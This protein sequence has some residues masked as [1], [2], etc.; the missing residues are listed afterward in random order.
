MIN[1]LVRTGLAVVTAVAAMLSLQVVFASSASAES[2]QWVGSGLNRH[3]YC[4]GVNHEVL[5]AKVS[6]GT[7]SYFN[8]TTQNVEASI[9]FNG[10]LKDKLA[11]GRCTWLRW[12]A[13][14]AY[15]PNGNITTSDK[16]KV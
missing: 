5:S 15:W 11:D 4:T 2:C 12:K 13:T 1:K 8:G 7:V 3:Q 9:Y 10:V 14:N 6:Q 16:L